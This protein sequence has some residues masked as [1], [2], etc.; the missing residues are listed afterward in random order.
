MFLLGDTGIQHLV[1]ALPTLPSLAVL[2]LR[3]NGI[4]HKGLSLIANALITRDSAGHGTQQV[5]GVDLIL[6]VDDTN[7]VTV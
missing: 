5:K 6:T 4:T 2:D 3:S 1:C 7:S